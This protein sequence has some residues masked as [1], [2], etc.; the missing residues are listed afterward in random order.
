MLASSQNL[1]FLIF[2][3]CGKIYNIFFLLMYVRKIE[4]KNDI[5]SFYDFCDVAPL[6]GA[7]IE[8]DY[9]GRG[10]TVHQVAPLAGAW[11]EIWL[12]LYR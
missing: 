6:A 11:I 10:I 5:S 8:I 4:R 1:L 2:E 3:T 12:C 7:W 9:G